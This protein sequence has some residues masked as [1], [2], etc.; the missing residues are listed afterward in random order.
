M[1]RIRR[2]IPRGRTADGLVVIAIIVCASV[3]VI[4]L[5]IPRP[6]QE[7]TLNILTFEDV[8]IQ[9]IIED[10]F[11]ESTYAEKYNI[12]DIEWINFASSMWNILIGSG[13]VDLVL[14]PSSYIS[15]FAEAGQLKHINR[16]VTQGLNETIAGVS[17]RGY[18]ER[19]TIWA[20]YGF[21]VTAFE[22]IVNETLLQENG[23][24][25]PET[26]DDLLSPQYCPIDPNA[27]LIGM[28]VPEL[29]T[30]G[31]EFQHLLTTS[32]GW[33]NGIQNLTAI[34]ANSR[35]FDQV[36][37]AE[38]AIM[39][40]EIGITLTT[41]EGRA[42]E[43]LPSSLQRVHLEDQVVII[44]DVVGIDNTTEH[45]RESEVFIE[46][47]LSPEC[48]AALLQDIGSRMPIRREAFDL[49]SVHESIYTEFN[50]TTRSDGLGINEL[51]SGEDFPLWHY[52]NSTV[53]S[54]G[55]NLTDCWIEV[56]NAYEN[57]SIDLSSLEHYREMLGALLEV[58]DPY[59]LLNESFTHD[60][61]LEVLN[62]YYDVD[63]MDELTYYLRVAANQRYETI[64]ATLSLEI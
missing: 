22:L 50:W 46:H 30:I 45:P 61:A 40:G 36:G 62:N 23:L 59:T 55:E 43:G 26:V 17:M 3:I 21:Y 25:I 2:I 29:L 51:L 35:F 18:D 6:P 60:Y 19:Q 10:S 32:R 42:H 15:L 8:I 7:V 33:D 20:C 63:Y 4:P 44:P 11:L 54:V 14:C 39:N 47:L 48:Q 31:H 12:V 24:T 16:S 1:S 9:T 37:A 13:T 34:Y 27:S 57:G 53:F 56:C 58:T 5:F 52:M 64:M 38:Q 41:F 49:T 28:E